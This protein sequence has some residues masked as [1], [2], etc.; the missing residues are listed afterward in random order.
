MSMQIL[1]RACARASLRA[2]TSKHTRHW[3]A[4]HLREQFLWKKYKM[5]AAQN[6][7]EPNGDRRE[8]KNE[9]LTI[10]QRY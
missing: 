4:S 3:H 2:L 9:Q 8:E 7:N 6:W 10:R 5:S 1:W